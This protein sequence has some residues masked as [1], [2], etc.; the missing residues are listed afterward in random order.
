MTT[1]ASPRAS[2]WGIEAYDPDVYLE[3]I[4]VEPAPPSHDLLERIHRGHVATFPFSNLDV[5]LRRHPGV[6]PESTADRMLHEGTG[7]YCFEHVQLMAG[8][9]ERLGLRVRRRLGRVRSP[10][11]PRTHMSLDVE[12]E[13]RRWMMDPGFG[14][15]QTGPIP[16]EDGAKRDEF[17]GTL[18]L[19]RI[20]SEEGIE[21]WVM[22]RDENV[23]HITD[24]LPVVR[25]DVSGGHHVTSTLPGAGPFQTMLIVSRFTDE[26]HVTITSGTRTIRRP[27]QETLRE[28][29]TAA[30]VIDAIADLGLPLDAGTTR[31]LSRRLGELD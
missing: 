8:V 22:R 1:T 21:Q 20:V 23:Q 14:L 29:L 30:Q 24:L 19:H 10:E 3:R 9:L 6:D 5:L 17:F 11:N 13:G 26:G 16:R 4:G 18:R 7:G 28:E 25:A 15:S 31:A 12:L 2:G 27:E